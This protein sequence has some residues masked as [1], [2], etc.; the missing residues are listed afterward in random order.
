MKR[1]CVGRR[2]ET[3]VVLLTELLGERGAHDVATQLGVSLVVSGTALTARGRDD[4][5]QVSQMF[6]K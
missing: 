1:I 6:P 4:Y 2:R 5:F 3:N